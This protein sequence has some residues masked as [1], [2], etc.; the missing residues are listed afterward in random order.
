LATAAGEK[1]ADDD[2]DD[3]TDASGVDELD[4]DD[5]GVNVDGVDVNDVEAVLASG[6]VRNYDAVLATA[7]VYVDV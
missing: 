3:A 2:G 6:Y 1:L 7:S 5:D 4:R